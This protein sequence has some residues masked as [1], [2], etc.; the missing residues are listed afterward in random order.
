MTTSSKSAVT[1]DSWRHFDADRGLRYCVIGIGVVCAISAAAI[2]AIIAV[3]PSSAGTRGSAIA[4]SA[5]ASTAGI[6]TAS[7]TTD[8]RASCCQSP[9][10]VGFAGGFGYVE[11]GPMPTEWPESLPSAQRDHVVLE[12]LHP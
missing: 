1:S 4:A 8:L 10:A 11:F 5:I 6:S 7:V 12:H 2:V 3:A 9:L